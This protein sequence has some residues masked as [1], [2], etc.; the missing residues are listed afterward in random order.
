VVGEATPAYLFHPRVPQRVRDFDP[1][2]KLI[3][4]LRDPVE[5]AYSQYQMQVR[6]RLHDFSFEEALAREDAYLSVE[7]QH[8]REDP[9]YVSPTGLRHSYR[10]RGRYA[11][12]LERWLELFPREQLIVLT[13]EELLADP[14][15]ALARIESFLGIPAGTGGAYPPAGVNHY[16]A[17]RLDTRERL[18]RE[19]EPHNRRLEEIIGRDP[20]WTRPRTQEVS[21]AATRSVSR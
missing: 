13:S 5:R 2:M 12:Q 17:M 10:A 11:E 16:A 8:I 6:N 14:A 21:A 3:A 1:R 4:V 18:A 19:F 9:S 20:N 7:L 15:A